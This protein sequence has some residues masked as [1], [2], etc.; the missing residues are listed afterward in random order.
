MYKQ[1]S[2]WCAVEH[3]QDGGADGMAVC[4]SLWMSFARKEQYMLLGVRDLCSTDTIKLWA[5]SDR[6]ASLH[7]KMSMH[8]LRGAGPGAGMGVT[9][10]AVDSIDCIGQ[11]GASLPYPSISTYRRY[12][13]DR[14]LLNLQQAAP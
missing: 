12:K 2:T 6:Q 9:G 14:R 11:A 10:R 8:Q 4:R 1:A 13:G 7:D 3:L 5:P